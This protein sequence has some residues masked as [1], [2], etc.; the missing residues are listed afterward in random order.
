MAVKSIV[1]GITEYFLQ[2][3]LLQDGIFRVD[4]LGQ[5]AV[6]YVIETGICDPVVQRYVDGSSER[7]YQFNFGSREYYSM[8]R[9][10]NIENSQFYE[11]LADWIEENSLSGNLP[12]M[13]EGMSA[14]EIEVLSPGYIYDGSMENAR[15]QIALRLLYYKEATKNE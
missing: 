8:D 1:E 6:E 12:E 10:Q 5:D 2:C 13:P 9:I 11:R 15:Y 14:E 4:A 3:P 7:Q